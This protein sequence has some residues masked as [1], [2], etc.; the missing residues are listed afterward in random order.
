MRLAAIHIGPHLHHLD[1]LAPLSALLNIPLIVTDEIVYSTATDSYP[2]LAV[3]LVDERKL[4]EFVTLSF[5]GVYTTL[6]RLLF[7]STFFFAENFLKKRLKTIWC[8]HGNSDKG[9][10]S[11]WMEVLKEEETILTYGSRI[12]QFLLEKGIQGKVLRVGN[13]RLAYFL[14][15]KEFY[16]RWLETKLSRQ[17][18]DPLKKTILYAPTWADS[19]GNS[20]FPHVLETLRT[21]GNRFN[22]LILLHPNLYLQ[23]PYEVELLKEM[24]VTLL[25]GVTP[26]YPLFSKVDLFVGDI[27]SSLGYDFLHFQRPMLLLSPYPEGHPNTALAAAGHFCPLS[28]FSS[29]KIEWALEQGPLQHSLYEETFS[30]WPKKERISFQD[31]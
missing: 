26:I 16:D 10:T 24:D 2:S 5:E 28:E 4:P 13:F 22:T 20:S 8:P 25:E 21:L 7:D 12:E 15:H 30:E 17:F 11:P 23:F 6:P 27:S 29:E 14:E 3:H 9:R 31:K 18:H 19:E 1:H